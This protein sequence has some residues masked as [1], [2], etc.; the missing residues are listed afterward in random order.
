[1]CV[2]NWYNPFAWFIRRAIKV[3]LEFI[4]DSK[5]LE[6][7]IDRKEFQCLLLKVIG[8]SQFNNHYSVQFFFFKKTL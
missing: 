4:A 1:V 3:N 2:L 5:V 6:T 8:I 7:G